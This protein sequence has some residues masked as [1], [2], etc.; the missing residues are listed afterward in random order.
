M[1]N[2]EN[3]VTG[4][5]V[6]FE[7][8]PN[9]EMY[10]LS[11]S[12][13]EVWN[14]ANRTLTEGTRDAEIDAIKAKTDSMNFTG[15]DIKATL[16]GEE[17]ITDSVSR[18]AS[19]A[20]VSLLATEANAT[21]NKNSIESTIGDLNN[22]SEAQV[23]N[24]VDIALTDYDPPTR[25]EATSDKN[26]IIAEV[27]IN[28]AKI[29]IIDTNVDAIKITVDLNLD[30]KVSEVGGMTEGE[31]HTGLDNYTNKD[32]WKSDVSLLATEANATINKTSIIAEVDIN[33]IKIDGIKA[34]TDLMAFTGTDI[35]STLDGEVVTTDSISRD[36]SKADISLLA[37][38]VNA[39]SNKNALESKIDIIDTN[40][41]TN[42]DAKISDI[43][44]DVLNTIS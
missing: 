13:L 27:D 7:A 33:E 21:S 43:P 16:D 39:T 40:I 42:L 34:K 22:I 23:N 41:D 29:D 4:L 35:K 10:N 12:P 9:E 18:I 44:E 24:Q 36:E 8:F 14:Y 1:L 32:D 19:K 26:E 15:T 28:E 3:D 25:A 31:L 20:D 30:A 17:V 5:N 38:E 6:W 11:L 37:T 2:G